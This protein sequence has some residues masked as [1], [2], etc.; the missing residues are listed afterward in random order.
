MIV[1][2]FY[3][4]NKKHIYRIEMLISQKHQIIHLLKKMK[5]LLFIIIITVIYKDFK[6]KILIIFNSSKRLKNRYLNLS[7]TRICEMTSLTDSH[8]ANFNLI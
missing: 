3:I 2:N 5:N 4:K 1:V 7:S 6:A 8:R